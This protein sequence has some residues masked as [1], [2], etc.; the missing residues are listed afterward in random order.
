L[1][2]AL[3]IDAK[4]H[5]FVGRVEIKP[6]HVA[7]LLDEEG[8]GRKFEAAGA[9]RLQTEGLEQA[10]DSALGNPGLLGDGTR[11]KLAGGTELRYWGRLYR[12][13]SSMT[14]AKPDL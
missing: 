10:M 5:G 11:S 4:H 1:D 9:V 3:L 14:W 12:R 6:D 8:I 13:A 7:Q 2:L